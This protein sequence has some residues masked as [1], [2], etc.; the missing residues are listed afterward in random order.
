M[1]KGEIVELI[2]DQGSKWKLCK[3]SRGKTGS[4]PAVHL[5]EFTGSDSGPR[6]TP[7]TPSEVQPQP[8]SSSPLSFTHEALADYTPPSADV[9]FYSKAPTFY[10]QS[11]QTK[12]L[13]LKKNE[14]LRV[15]KQQGQ[16]L[17]CRNADGKRGYVKKSMVRDLSQPESSPAPVRDPPVGRGFTHV[18]IKDYSDV[19]FFL[20]LTIQ[21]L[22]LC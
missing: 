6:A 13:P 22:F 16:W 17:V 7:T 8:P 18:A 3:N 14:K 10:S 5:K 1:K 12:S 11:S 21:R 19:W 15:E 9:W 4:I 2:E 20:Q